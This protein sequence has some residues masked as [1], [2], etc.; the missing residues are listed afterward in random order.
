MA[1]MDSRLVYH[2]ASTEASPARSKIS[3]DRACSSESDRGIFPVRDMR[4]R[5]WRIAVVVSTVQPHAMQDIKA[6]LTPCH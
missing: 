6:E 3:E 5:A 2:D 4:A 1:E